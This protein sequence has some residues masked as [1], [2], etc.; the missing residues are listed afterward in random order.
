MIEA[1]KNI[2]ENYMICAVIGGVLEYLSPEKTRKTLKTCIV[3]IMLIATLSPVFS[4]NIDFPRL[5][6][7]DDFLSEQ[8]YNNL[9]RT[10]SLTEKT[11]YSEIKNI[12]IN[13]GVDE[14][15]IYIETTVDDVKN[16]VILDEIKIEVSKAFENKIPEIKKAVN[17][18]YSKILKVGVKNE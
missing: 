6:G 8:Q 3:S 18:E 16:N 13:L 12:L 9:Y 14:Y 5:Y 15:E 1:I 11:L 17:E 10:A 7:E 4:L 2:F